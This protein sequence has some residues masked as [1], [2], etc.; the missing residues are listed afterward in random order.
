MVIP[1]NPVVRCTQ[2]YRVEAPR[3]LLGSFLSVRAAAAAA[4]VDAATS[5][6]SAVVATTT[7]ATATAALAGGRLQ[8]VPA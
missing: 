1:G 7:A 3:L 5:A 6:S 4:A 8:S 2:E